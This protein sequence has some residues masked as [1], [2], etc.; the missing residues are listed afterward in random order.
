[1]RAGLAFAGAVGGKTGSTNDYRDAWFVGFSSSVV[2]G[3]WVGFDQPERIQRG[4]LGRA[5][6][7]AY[8]VRLHAPRGRGA[9]RPSHLR[10]H[11]DLRTEELCRIVVSTCCRRMPDLHRV[12]QGR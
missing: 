4:R 9:A 8:L 7:A 1:M 6:R 5:R 11:P 12:F 2:A 3:V 10:R